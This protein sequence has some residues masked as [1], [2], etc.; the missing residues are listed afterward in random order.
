M[1]DHCGCREY[2]PIAELTA[3]HEEILTLAWTLAESGGARADVRD[4]LV[5]LLDAHV[6]KEESGLYPV[7]VETGDLSTEANDALEA[8]HRELRATLL[9]GAFDR[10][11][12][13]ALAA[14]VEEEEMELFPAAMFGFDDDGWDRLADAHTLVSP[15]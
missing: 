3:D 13:Y 7:L 10:R 9:S 5:A 14:H 1:C 4:E 15:S 8:E 6:A 12:F 2:G 11:D